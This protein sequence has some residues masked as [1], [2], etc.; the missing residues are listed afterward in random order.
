[1]SE[2]K[3]KFFA[4]SHFLIGSSHSQQQNI[5]SIILEKQAQY[6]LSGLSAVVAASSSGGFVGALS[7]SQ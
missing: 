7:V 1:M 2:R 3:E 4:E 5:E 6:T